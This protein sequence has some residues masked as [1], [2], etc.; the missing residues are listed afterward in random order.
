MSLKFKLLWPVVC[1]LK[2]AFCYSFG[3]YDGIDSA[4]FSEYDGVFI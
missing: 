3:R 2:P 4:L 1:N